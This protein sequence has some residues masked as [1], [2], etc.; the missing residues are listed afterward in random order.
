MTQ[1]VTSGTTTSTQHLVRRRFK[2]SQPV[3]AF[4]GHAESD[5]FVLCYH[6]VSP[7]WKAALSV[8]PDALESQLSALL[9]AGWHGTTFR[10]AVVRPPSRRTFA[11]TFDDAFLSVLEHAYPVL[12]RLGL[13]ATMFAPTAFLSDDRRRLLWPGLAEWAE[14][15]EAFELDSMSWENLRFLATHGWEI[16]SHTRT[17]PRLTQLDDEAL[18]SELEASRQEC[19]ANLGTDCD[20]IAYPYGDVDSRVARATAA[21]G[22]AAAA[23]LSSSLAPKGLH[24]WPRIGIYHDDQMWRFRLKVDRTVR[25]IRATR[26][27]RE[28][29]LTTPLSSIDPA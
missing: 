15:P 6:A 23:A 24:R 17:H 3:D 9:R 14:T 27:W 5:V 20:T 12:T 25:R 4:G 2:R 19:I 29:R 26:M 18:R 16:G 1:D 22:Y 28:T 8:T 10:E 7:T 21:S 13:A 11:I